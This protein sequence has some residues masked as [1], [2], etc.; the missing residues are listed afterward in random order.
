MRRIN[1]R[2]TDNS[3]DFTTDDAFCDIFAW[4]FLALV[5][6]LYVVL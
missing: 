4:F 3:G 5:S 2:L 6:I 1:M